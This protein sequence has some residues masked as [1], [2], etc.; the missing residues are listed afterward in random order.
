MLRRWTLSVK[1]EPTQP[2]TLAELTLDYARRQAFLA[3]RELKLTGLE[4]RLLVE[5]SMHAGQA[6]SHAELL[7]SVWGPGNSGRTGAVRTVIKQL[8]SKL[9]DDAD[10]PTYIHNQ[11]GYGYRMQDPDPTDQAQ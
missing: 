3:G 5:L 9:G 11:P 6:R 1:T 2:F 10:A 4:Y 7:R 8:R